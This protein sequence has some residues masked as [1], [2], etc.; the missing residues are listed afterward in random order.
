MLERT[1]V[2]RNQVASVEPV[3]QV[4]GIVGAEVSTSESRLPPRG[5]AYGQKCY[6]ELA[7]SAMNVFTDQSVRVCRERRVTSEEAR[8]VASIDQIHVG[9]TSPAIYRVTTAYVASRASV[10]DDVSDRN[11]TVSR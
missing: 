4:E 6:I 5:M 9:G 10:Y 7:I 11:L 1:P 8:F 2:V 3:K